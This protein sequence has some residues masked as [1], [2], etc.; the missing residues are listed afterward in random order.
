MIVSV[1]LYHSH[2]QTKKDK[3]ITSSHHLSDLSVNVRY[4]KPSSDN[5]HLTYDCQCIHERKTTNFGMLEADNK[6]QNKY[7]KVYRIIPST[8][9]IIASHCI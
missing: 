3:N 5:I 9:E 2:S 7:A 6:T 4:N 8:M 1:S